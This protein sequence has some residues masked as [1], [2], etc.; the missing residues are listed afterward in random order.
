MPEERGKR[1]F[2]NYHKCIGCESCE[3]ICK[4]LYGEPRIRMTRTADGLMF[5]LYCHHCP[6]PPCAKACPAKAIVRDPQGPVLHDAKICR[7][8]KAMACM[9][10]CPFQAVFPTGREVPVLKCDLCAHRRD[11]GLLPACVEVCPCG[12]IFYVGV[13]AVKNLRTPESKTAR[14]RIMAHIKELKKT[15]KDG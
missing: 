5:P 12:A 3:T 7:E 15:A 10:A 11:R 1:L 13:G 2:I 9:R 8:T 14:K 4:F 6:N